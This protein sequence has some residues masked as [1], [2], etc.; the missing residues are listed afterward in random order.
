MVNRPVYQS[1]VANAEG[2]QWKEADGSTW[3]MVYLPN[4]SVKG[5]SARQFAGALAFLQSIGAY[6]STGDTY[7]GEVKIKY[8]PA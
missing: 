1:L 2:C 5:I 8:E 7:F 3:S 4:A 6:R